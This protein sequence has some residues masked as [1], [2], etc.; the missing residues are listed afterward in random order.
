MKN[1][2]TFVKSLVSTLLLVTGP[3]AAGEEASIEEQLAGA[4]SLVSLVAVQ[5]DSRIDVFGPEPRGRMILDR[6]GYFSTLTTRSSLPDFASNNRMQGTPVEYEAIAKGANAHYGTYRVDGLTGTI[7]FQVEVST[8]PNWEGQIQDRVFK[9]EG[10]LLSYVNPTST[11]GAT[12]VEVVWR[13]LGPVDHA[14]G[15]SDPLGYSYSYGPN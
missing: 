10:N 3:A 2:R 13:R 1:A 11:V 5:G 6:D 15:A 4:W 7:S 8:F 9:L 14:L 12:S